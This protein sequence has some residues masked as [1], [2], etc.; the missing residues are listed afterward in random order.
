V[1]WTEHSSIPFLDDQAGVYL[2]LV[3][4]PAVVQAILNLA[5]LR[6]GETLWDLGCGDG[7]VII[8][9]AKECGA[10][11]LGIELNEELCA[12]AE[13]AVEAEGLQNV[14]EIVRGDLREKTLEPVDVIVVYL[15]GC[16]LAGVLLQR[17]HD[18]ISAG[19]RVIS[20]DAALPGVEPTCMVTVECGDHLYTLY[21]YGDSATSRS[22]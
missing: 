16:D 20:V 15:D 13:R 14:V 22:L 8:A 5:H 2:L 12:M 3:S 18:R 9:A 1:N 19:G 10:R 21:R 6:P 4:P 17:L 7:R 11:A